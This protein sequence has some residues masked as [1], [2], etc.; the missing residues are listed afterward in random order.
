MGKKNSSLVDKWL[1]DDN[2][3]LLEAWA[4][5][6]YTMS[7]IARKIGTDINTISRWKREYKEIADALNRGKEI[8]DYLVENALLKSALGFRSKETKVITTM[9]YGKV[10]ETVTE[11]TD[12]EQPP[13][14]P[15]IQMWLYNRQKEKWKNMNAAK[16]VFDD[17]EEDTSIE[18]TVSRASKNESGFDEGID[19]KNISLRKRTKAEREK[20]EE[21]VKRKKKEEEEEALKTTEIVDDEEEFTGYDE[22]LDE[23]PE[24]WEE[25]EE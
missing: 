16:N 10:V 23:W 1:E 24:D 22:N 12:R 8:T 21:E 5:D 2:L 6:G 20:Y 25:A 11:T 15:A 3:L 9:R 13:S 4:R 19:D 18:I 14:V 7:D 17:M